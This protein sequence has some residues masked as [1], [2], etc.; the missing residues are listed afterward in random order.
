MPQCRGSSLGSHAA[1]QV[2]TIPRPDTAQ[3]DRHVVPG[4]GKQGNRGN[5]RAPGLRQQLGGG[6][7]WCPRCGQALLAAG[8]EGKRGARVL[9]WSPVTHKLAPI[10]PCRRRTRQRTHR[11]TFVLCVCRPLVSPVGPRLVGLGG[12]SSIPTAAMFAS[13]S[14]KLPNFNH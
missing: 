8:K 14:S 7:S 6:P 13:L 3:G 2:P 12:G 4:A 5:R 11:S 9:G 1:A 10:Q